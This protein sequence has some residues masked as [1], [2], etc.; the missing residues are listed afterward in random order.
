MA[1][2]Q[3]LLAELEWQV[4]AGANEAIGEVPSLREVEW[5]ALG[6]RHLG[7]KLHAS[8]PKTE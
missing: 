2:P 7:V 8:I 4:A 1:N 3:Q 5:R 6:I